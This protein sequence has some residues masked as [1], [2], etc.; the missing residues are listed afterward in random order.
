MTGQSVLIVDDEPAIRRLLR[1]SLGAQGYRTLEAA[2]AAEALARIAADR[3]DVVILDLGLPD[4]DG[5]EVIRAVRTGNAVPIVVLTSRESAACGAPGATCSNCGCMCRR[6]ARRSGRPGTAAPYPHRNR[7]RLPPRR[8]GDAAMTLAAMALDALIPPG[9]VLDRLRAPDKTALLN[10]LARAAGES[11]G[12]PPAGIAA[13]L[14]AREALGST[15]IG[16]GIAVPHA[17]IAALSA[18]AGFLARLDR[19]VA[20]DAV[21]GRPVDLVFLLLSPATD[22]DHL[23]ALAAVSRRLR[24]PEVAEAMRTAPPAAL[25]AALLGA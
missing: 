25:R 23:R 11:L 15:G 20:F 6:S 8:A 5:L 21:D 10:A 17:R 3:P 22:A 4:R 19:P 18:P 1:T 16:G 14:A 9:H 7:G 2:T 24:R 12:L 13:A